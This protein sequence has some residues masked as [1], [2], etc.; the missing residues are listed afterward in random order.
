MPRKDK[1]G[2]KKAQKGEVKDQLSAVDKTFFELSIND[3]NSKLTNLRK[4]NNELEDKNVVTE[5]QMMQLDDDRADII[6]FLSRTTSK[7]SNAIKDLEEKLF[8]LAK[9]RTEETERFQSIIK[10]WESKYKAMHD[11][12]SSE[13]KLLAGKLNYLEE[14]RLQHDDLMAKFDQQEKNLNEQEQRHKDTLYE[15]EHKQIKQKVHLKNQLEQRLFELSNEFMR[16]NHIRQAAHVQRMTRE[17]IALNNEIERLLQSVAELRAQNKSLAPQSKRQRQIN[18]GLA[19]ENAQLANMCKRYVR[20]IGR[21]TAECERLTVE[22][23]KIDATD[24]MRRMAEV[25]EMTSRKELNE[26]KANVSALQSTLNEQQQN[27]HTHQE[28]DVKCR[29]EIG[30]LL[31]MLRRLKEMICQ[32]IQCKDT[33]DSMAFEMQRKQLL[34]ELLSILAPLTDFDDVC[35]GEMVDVAT[36]AGVDDDD[37]MTLLGEHETYR[38]GTIGITPRKSIGNIMMRNT[39]TSFR[40]RRKSLLELQKQSTID[41]DRKSPSLIGCAII[42]ISESAIQTEAIDSMRCDEEQQG[43]EKK[44]GI[45]RKKSIMQKSIESEDGDGNK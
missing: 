31:A 23:G 41:T 45:A 9:V 27:L 42:D 26:F 17:N 36:A 21:L 5:A 39:Q 6:A 25:R 18:H 13:I 11:Q 44:L 3:L 29:L 40:A 33:A 2:D 4:R 22:T 12:L 14:F 10:D 38:K 34:A 15:L 32:I 20:I 24:K 1:K 16:T 7:Q 8:Q 19:E 35:L 43:D 30:Q 28:M 37:Q